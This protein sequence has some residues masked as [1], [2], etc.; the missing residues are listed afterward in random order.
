MKRLWKIIPPCFSDVI[1]FEAVLNG[2][3]GLG[4]I[5]DPSRYKPIRQG[6]ADQNGGGGRRGGHRDDNSLAMEAGNTG[7]RLWERG[8]EPRGHRG[9]HG[10]RVS[11]DTRVVNSDIRNADIITG[12]EKKVLAAFEENRSMD[13]TF[14]L[15][16]HAPSSSMIGSDLEANAAQIR[17]VSSIPAAYVNIDGGKD[18]L[19]GIGMTLETMGKLLLDKR[20][21]IPGGVNLLGCNMI[22]WTEEQRSAAED[23]LRKQGFE[24]LSCWGMKESTER[25]KTA[26][27]AQINLVVSVAGLHL[28]RYM[29]TEFNIPYT[30]GAPFGE[31]SCETLLAKLRGE[32]CEGQKGGE[33][34]PTALI[35]G[36]QLTANAIREALRRRGWHGIQVASLYDMDKGLMEPGDG[37]LTAEE[38]LE[39]RLEAVE[40]AQE[41]AD[42]ILEDYR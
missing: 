32:A 23:W 42:I 33:E 3:E 25:L 35:V 19:Y 28:A 21:K 6:N 12:T 16:C 27:A 8:Q 36:E 39:K 18:Y 22:D 29:E 17:E 2:T 10:R 41:K 40:K 24:L 26:A 15:L 1:G 5:D 11:R 34:E 37:K 9:G 20:E 31:A 4:I 30:V 13:P 38:D 7:N 14:V